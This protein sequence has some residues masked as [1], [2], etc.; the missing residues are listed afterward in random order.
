[1]MCAC[2]CGGQPRGKTSRYL[3]GHN[4][5]FRTGAAATRYEHGMSC[6][7][8][9]YSWAS[10]FG[11]CTNPKNPA[12]KNYG[13]RGI[14]VCER[15]HDFRNFLDD[16]GERPAGM[17][18]DRIDNDGN[19]EPGNCRWATRSQQAKNRRSH[20]FAG[21]GWRPYKGTDQETAS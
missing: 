17:T 14:R 19:Y 2:G 1:M 18:L 5:Q 6:T 3:P 12:W 21:R 10:I 9:W 4:S 8:T 20:G 13:A 16:M 7:P 11:R 15:W